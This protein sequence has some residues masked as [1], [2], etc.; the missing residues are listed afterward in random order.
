M[1]VVLID[2]DCKRYVPDA[3]S[4]AHLLLDETCRAQFLD[5]EHLPQ[6]ED[7]CRCVILTAL[8]GGVKNYHRDLVLRNA[9]VRYWVFCILGVALKSERSQLAESVE[10]TIAESKTP[11]SIVFDDSATLA[12]TARLCQ[13][14]LREKKR[15]VVAS[16]N[17]PLARQCSQILACWLEDWDVAAVNEAFQAQY[18]TADVILAVGEKKAD[19]ELPAPQFGMGRIYAW[20]EQS[21]PRSADAKRATYETLTG[22]GWNLSAAADVYSSDLRLENYALDLHRGQLSAASLSNDENF[23]IWDVYGLPAR[24]RDYTGE[25]IRDFLDR[26]CCFA[27]LAERFQ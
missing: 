25:A 27:E 17:A 24:V 13:Q 8:S 16:N 14:P 11:Y 12:Q 7:G 1:N 4:V 3:Q 15:C 26:Q 20:L 21:G 23:V 10:A 19:F 2:S 18:E 9:Q 5:A 6:L 22:C